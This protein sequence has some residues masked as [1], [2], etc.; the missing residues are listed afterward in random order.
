MIICDCLLAIICRHMVVG[1]RCHCFVLCANKLESNLVIS[2][3]HKWQSRLMLRAREQARHELSVGS[4]MPESCYGLR[5]NP[6]HLVVAPIFFVIRLLC[7][8]CGELTMFSLM[9]SVL[10]FRYLRC[11]D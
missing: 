4:D 7:S 5:G 10:C 1:L 9:V 2:Y 11:S 6:V 8:T 3:G